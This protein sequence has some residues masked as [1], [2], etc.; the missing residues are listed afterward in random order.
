MVRRV[1]EADGTPVAVAREVFAVV[2]DVLCRGMFSEDLQPTLVRK[3]TDVADEAA[4]LSGAPNV[5][6]FF[7]VLAAA[8]LQGVRRK[9]EELVAWL[10]GLIDGQ[11]EIRRC[12][13]ATGEVSKNDMLDVLLDMEGEVQEEG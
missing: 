3:L 1:A 2:V 11:I 6:D 7:P 4:V 5:S 8:D 12:S 9:A 10:Y 13:R